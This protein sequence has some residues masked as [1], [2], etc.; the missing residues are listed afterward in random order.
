MQCTGKN[1]NFLN[2]NKKK[3]IIYRIV[4]HKIKL[5]LNHCHIILK[6]IRTNNLQPTILNAI[7][8][9]PQ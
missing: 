8:A 4:T 5:L 6:T 9:I 1:K 2:L 3:R 7:P